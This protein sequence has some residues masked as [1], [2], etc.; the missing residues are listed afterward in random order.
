MVQS[1]RLP[2]IESDPRMGASAFAYIPITLIRADRAQNLI[3]LLD[4]SASVNVL[5]YE[6]GLK[7]SPGHSQGS[8]SF[9]NPPYGFFA[10]CFVDVLLAVIFSVDCS[11]RIFKI[12]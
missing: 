7:V 4:T 3:G 2:F 12:R 11:S 1:I 10:F 8:F 5:P 9:L 6:A